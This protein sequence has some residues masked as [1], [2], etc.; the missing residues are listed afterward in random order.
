MTTNILQSSMVA[1]SG[2]SP[3]ESDR[4]SSDTGHHGTNSTYGMD[5]SMG[6]SRTSEI[7][8]DSDSSKPKEQ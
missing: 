1:N 7:T 6:M 5:D 2:K 3:S 8:E 4:Q